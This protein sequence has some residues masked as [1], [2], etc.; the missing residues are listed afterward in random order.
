MHTM[1]RTGSKIV[2][3]SYFKRMDADGAWDEFVAIGFC[4]SQI[5]AAL[6]V[7]ALNGGGMPVSL[8]DD[9]TWVV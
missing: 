1:K 3:G 7:S 9:W 5:T 4:T 6:M 2:V 8:P